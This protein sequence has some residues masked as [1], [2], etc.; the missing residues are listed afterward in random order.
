VSDEQ[1]VRK[2]RW[3]LRGYHIL[4][5]ALVV[6]ICWFGLYRWWRLRSQLQLRMDAIRAAGYP[7]T[8]AELDDWYS[9]PDGVDN[10]ADV[11]LDAASWYRGPN[12]PNLVP[13]AGLAELPG[14]TEGLSEEMKKA[15]DVYLASNKKT[16][17]LLHEAAGIEHSRYPVN[18]SAG[19][20]ALM[21]YLSSIRYMA[22]LLKAEAVIRAE[23]GEID[24]AIESI[25][26]NFGVARSLSGEP[27]L[28]SQLVRVACEGLGVSTVERIVNRR[29]LDDEQLVV[30][31][32]LVSGAGSGLKFPISMMGERCSMLDIYLNPAKM[33]GQAFGVPYISE[34]L[35]TAFKAT[36]LIDKGAMLYLD[37]TDEFLQAMELPDHERIA[38]AKA[39]VKKLEEASGIQA[40]MVRIIAPAYARLVELDLRSIALF[41]VA[42][43]GL[44]VERYRLA[45]GKLP[46]LLGELVPG[47]L[48]SV[49]KDPFDGAQLRYK[50]LEKGYVV[51]SIGQDGSD[52]GGREHPRGERKDPDENWDVTFIVE[53]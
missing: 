1:R 20:N 16:L 49:P 33:G 39:I 40:R 19:M 6:G 12:E 4:I 14:R 24:Q 27:V 7:V 48:D 44:A 25:A 21:P 29:E 42:R 34:V 37:F 38:A 51:Y 41:R 50:R 10:A 11:I 36:G 31:G 18:L 52:D 30:L 32:R 2:K 13:V 26:A 8:C 3:K 47:Y 28:V 22:R 9:I 53:R 17:E 15:I 23:D 45:V 46:D 43:L 35:F 5:L